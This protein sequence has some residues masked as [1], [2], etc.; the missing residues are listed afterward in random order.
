MV[1]TVKF[2]LFRVEQ[3]LNKMFTI[4]SAISNRVLM[5]SKWTAQIK[6]ETSSVR[7]FNGLYQGGSITSLV[8]NTTIVLLVVPGLD[9]TRPVVAVP[10]IC[11][12]WAC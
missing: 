11:A 5:Q 2:S 4:L 6:Y 9:N 8:I 1:Y 7:N 3:F 12:A 10:T